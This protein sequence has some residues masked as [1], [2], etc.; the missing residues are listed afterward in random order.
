MQCFLRFR[1]C[2]VVLLFFC[3]VGGDGRWESEKVIKYTK[4]QSA[5]TPSFFIS[6]ILLHFFSIYEDRY[7]LKRCHWLTTACMFYAVEKYHKSPSDKTID[8]WNDQ[9]TNRKKKPS[10]NFCWNADNKDK[11]IEIKTPKFNVW[12][13]KSIRL[14]R[15]LRM[16]CMV[17]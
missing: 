11:S 12:H 8:T 7:Q 17:F 9:P 5:S 15:P 4:D 1:R 16:E 13:V 10:P 14:W 3:V 2:G 6:G